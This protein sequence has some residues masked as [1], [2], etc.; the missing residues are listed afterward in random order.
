DCNGL[1]QRTLVDPSLVVPDPSLSIRE[2]AIAPW[3]SAVEKESG[4]TFLTIEGVAETAG[5]DLDRPWNRLSKTKREQILYGL[6]E[7]R[8]R[9]EWGDDEEQSQGSWAV[10]FEGVIPNLERKYQ[11]T[12]SERMRQHYA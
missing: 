10:R 5:I 1:G 12:A 4:W 11:E 2:G 3:A 8:I 9:L 6:G 7:K